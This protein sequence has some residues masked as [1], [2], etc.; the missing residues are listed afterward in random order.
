MSTTAAAD[1]SDSGAA[2]GRELLRRCIW[3][4]DGRT[5]STPLSEAVLAEF[6]NDLEI[7][8][9]ALHA[10]AIRLERAAHD[11]YGL[12]PVGLPDFLR[13]VRELRTY[14]RADLLLPHV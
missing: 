13:L 14:W 10:P 11:L 5:A 4:Y 12:K 1:S 3:A 9:G 7:L 2:I 6:K 8:V